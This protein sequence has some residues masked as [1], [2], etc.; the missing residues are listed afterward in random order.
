MAVCKG[1][2][3]SKLVLKDVATGSPE[4]TESLL[5]LHA[6]MISSIVIAIIQS[7]NL[8]EALLVVLYLVVLMS[9]Q[10]VAYKAMQRLNNVSS[11][12]SNPDHYHLGPGGGIFARMNLRTYKALW[13]LKDSNGNAFPEDRQLKLYRLLYYG[14]YLALFTSLGIYA[15]YYYLIAQK[16]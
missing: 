11:L 8:V 13:T 12:T 3:S 1:V 2:I 9:L 10:V 15:I 5:V 16:L 4:V 14:G 7:M 6:C